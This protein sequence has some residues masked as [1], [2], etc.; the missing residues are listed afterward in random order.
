M[1]EIV[2]IAFAQTVNVPYFLSDETDQQ[3]FINEN[4][5]SPVQVVRIENF[6]QAIRESGGNGLGGYLDFT[7]NP[8]YRVNVLATNLE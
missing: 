3:S 7:F 6:I 5:S 2:S 1:G 8:L 4:L